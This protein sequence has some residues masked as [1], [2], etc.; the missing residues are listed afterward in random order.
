MSTLPIPNRRMPT[1]ATWNVFRLKWQTARGLMP[2]AEINSRGG[3]VGVLYYG[4]TALPVPE[5]LDNLASSGIHL[6]TCRVRAFPFGEEVES[7]VADHDLIFVVEQN[8]DGQMRTLLVNELQTDPA[9]LIPILYFA[10]LSISADFIDAQI[11]EYYEEHKLARLT[12]VTS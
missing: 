1:S 2:K 12:E 8:R 5:A 6:D 10:G 11:S 9:K 3:R 7:F 4:T